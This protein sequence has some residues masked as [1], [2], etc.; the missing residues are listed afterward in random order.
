MPDRRPVDDATLDRL[1]AAASVAMAWP[2]TPTLDLRRLAPHTRPLRRALLVALVALLL[3]AGS[4][5]A[6]GALGIGPLRILFT[7]AL[8]SPNVP[9]TPLGSRLS[10]GTS[11]TLDEF[12]HLGH[13]RVEV[14]RRRRPRQHDRDLAQHS[15]GRPVGELGE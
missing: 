15:V 13:Q 14:G 8:P 1:L 3:S 11:T 10:L 9:D 6:A 2:P 4:A 7:Q 5:V 12:N